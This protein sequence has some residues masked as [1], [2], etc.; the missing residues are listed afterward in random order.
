MHDFPVDCDYGIVHDVSNL[1]Q[2]MEN[3]INHY[4]E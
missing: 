1:C 4:S 2:M 3:D